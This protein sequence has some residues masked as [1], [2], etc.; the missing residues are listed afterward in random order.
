VRASRAGSVDRRAAKANV[1]ADLLDREAALVDE[2]MVPAAEEHEVVQAGLAAM[3][4]V[5][6]VVGVHEPPLSAAGK[7]AAAI[8]AA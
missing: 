5:S 8:T 4:P 1:T 7:P 3:G 6:N 2:A